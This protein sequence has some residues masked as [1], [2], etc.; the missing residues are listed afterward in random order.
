MR[1]KLERVFK[2]TLKIVVRNSAHSQA[3]DD[4]TIGSDVFSTQI[5]DKMAIDP[6]ML[7]AE[8]RVLLANIPALIVTRCVPFALLLS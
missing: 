4:L 5:S 6:Q 1:S 3:T 7:E 2:N 8:R